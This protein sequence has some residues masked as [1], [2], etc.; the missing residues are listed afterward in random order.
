MTEFD[1]EKNERKPAARPD[2]M[3]RLETIP[4]LKEEAMTIEAMVRLYC[5]KHHLPDE[6]GLCE[7]CRSFLEYAKKRLACCPYGG[8]KPVCAKCRIH[9]Y[10]PEEKEKARVI[11][12]WAG[13]RL[14]FSHPV[15]TVKHLLY[16]RAEPPEKPRN[17]RGRAKPAEGAD[18][19]ARGSEAP[20]R[21]TTK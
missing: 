5:R 17:L 11:M 13:P 20:N 19:T 16:S 8:E 15:L 6:D 2:R 21:K 14:L 4:R 9:C 18:K 12:R 10:K 3:A 1:A 7:D